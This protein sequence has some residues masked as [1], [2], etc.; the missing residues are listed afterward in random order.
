MLK[1]D[2]ADVVIADGFNGNIVLKTMEG[3]AS[4]MVNLLK[5]EIK[6]I[7]LVLWADL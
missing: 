2:L 1:S 5:T 6:K 4:L 7:Q 3:T